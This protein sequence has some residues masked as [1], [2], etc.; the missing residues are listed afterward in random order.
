MNYDQ[1][2]IFTL[3]KHSLLPTPQLKCLPFLSLLIRPLDLC[4]QSSQFGIS[5]S[6]VNAFCF[7]IY[8][9]YSLQCPKTLDLGGSVL[10][11]QTQLNYNTR[12]GNCVLNFLLPSKL[13]FECEFEFTKYLRF[14][15]Y[16][17][18]DKPNSF[19]LD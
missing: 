15:I 8:C 7:N 6:F 11:K 2:Q 9:K 19:E 4:T 3:M 13:K 17:N 14:I 18:T 16:P 10:N 1:Y 5:I 12:I